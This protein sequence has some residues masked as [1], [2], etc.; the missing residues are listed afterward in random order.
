MHT[1]LEILKIKLKGFI[2]K[3][4]KNQIIRGLLISVG[5]LL[6]FILAV[7]LVEYYYWSNTITRT[8]IF[9]AF[10]AV[11]LLVVVH[12]IFI[13]L[14]K[15]FQLGKTLSN[16]E[17]ARI[18]GNYFPDVSD[19]LLNTLQLEENMKKQSTTDLD[20]LLA[21]VRQKAAKLTPIPFK[22]AIDFKQ[23][24]KY[25]RYLFPL[26]LIII[27]ILIVAPSFI[28]G[29]SNRIIKHSIEFE[30]P[31][32][33]RVM[34]LNDSLTA[35]QHEDFTV[36]LRIEGEE[37]PIQLK[38]VQGK[39]AY[40]IPEIEP[41]Y[42]EY[43]FRDLEGDI[44]FKLQTEEYESSSY[45]LKVN[46]KPVIY[47]FT[48]SMDF[49]AYLQKPD[50]VIENAGDLVVPEGTRL[51]WSIFTKD[52]REIVFRKGI[53]TE[54]INVQKGN[55]FTKSFM[56]V[57]DFN[58]T[59][60]GRNEFV[61]Y[62]DSMSFYVELIKDE[63][64]GIELE[65]FTD[66][67]M[68]GYAHLN[69]VISD[70][71]G[72]YELAFYYQKDADPGMKWE[73]QIIKIDKELNRQFFQYTLQSGN[74]NLKPGESLS[75]YFEVKDNDAINN[76]KATK[77]KTFSLSFPS[78]EEIADNL[79]DSSEKFKEELEKAKNEIED[80]TLEMEELQNALFEKKELNWLDKQQLE[81]MMSKE[82]ELFDQMEN[83]LQLK[84]EMNEMEDILEKEMD[85][86][87]SRKMEEL[88]NLLNELMDEEMKK[89]LEEMKKQLE[90]L[91]KGKLNELLE[92]MKM[93]NEDL[94]NNLDQ[95]LELF[96]QLEFEKKIEEAIEK[97]D[98]LADQQKE[99]AK[100]NL[101]KEVSKEEALSEQKKMEE[102]FNK[103]EEEIE[104]AEALNEQLSEPFNF[105]MDTTD[106]NDIKSDQE[107]AASDLQKGKQKKA[108]ESQD[109]AGDKM[110]DM[111]NNLSMM[112]ESAMM[113]QMG[114][115]A[116][117]VKKMLD[118]LLDLS[119]EQEKLI[120]SYE[121]VSLNDPKYMD[122]ADQQKLLQDDFMVVNDS[123]LALSKRQIFIQPFIL[124]ESGKITDYM[125]KSLFSMQ[126]RKK[127]NALGE[128]QYVMTSMNNLALM[129]EESLNQMN[130]S[131]SMMSGKPG[132]GKC[133]KPGPGTKPNLGDVLQMQQGLNDGMGK[134]GE[135]KEG[136]GQKGIGSEQLARMA[137]M[138][139]EIRR[140]LQDYIDELEAEGGNGS[141]LNKLTED[142]EKVEQDL[143]NRRLTEET[144]KR[145]KDLEVRLLKAKDAELKREK[146]NK[147][148]SKEGKTIKRSNQI[149]QLQ[150]KDNVITQEEILKSVPIEMSP[151]YK[152]LFKKY[153]Y[154]LERENGSQ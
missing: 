134:K 132:K 76:Y 129:L 139:A 72:F 100:E 3:Y 34:L 92:Q 141:A 5:L 39:F 81:Q 95:N 91:D 115:D 2:R 131:L 54:I 77:S 123:L 24:L 113:E 85:P 59:F 53:E 140:R 62:S 128:Q 16:N 51:N 148:E 79:E 94:K 110:K 93:N 119:F 87:L 103:I 101:E 96:K 121:E 86:E 127:G 133:N 10:L 29:P 37:I 38:M 149:E 73:K 28:T 36:Q 58:Y 122:H 17:A 82:E 18:I 118:N 9:Y 120:E 35:L 49:P 108:A 105:E 4:Y 90:E 13:P 11:S 117:Q 102:N 98:Q 111:A 116:E 26:I 89:E 97:L 138:Q 55:V 83:L 31:L 99:L 7:N 27:I 12:Y 30:K 124:K 80:L 6:F 50:E 70:D 75:Y 78:E 142:M 152:E 135:K 45:H 43:V 23:N 64:P 56:A 1:E 145:Q 65:E 47:N 107:K 44:Y 21:G 151:Y 136:E 150:Y 126:E 8:I 146:E 125:E 153:L 15:L 114:E 147:R 104:K 52:T 154:K 71:H 41:G 63:Y 57:N 19:K 112:M 42:Y 33:Y 25:L 109:S 60:F 46:P 144:L 32:P 67:N 106:V 143:I 61:N 69:G 66:E 22:K 14:V 130:Q 74:F 137:A 84:E 68:P 88:E 20:L 40:R 48:V